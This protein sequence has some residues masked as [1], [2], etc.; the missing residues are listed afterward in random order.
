[1]TKRITN[2]GL[3]ATSKLLDVVPGRAMAEGFSYSKKT[4]TEAGHRA[5]AT[6]SQATTS[7]LDLSPKAE[8]LWGQMAFPEAPAC[9]HNDRGPCCNLPLAQTRASY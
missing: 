4:K 6:A 5:M 7:V 3:T 9:Q 1:M 2:F 8:K